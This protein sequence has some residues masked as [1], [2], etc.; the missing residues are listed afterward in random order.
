MIAQEKRVATIWDNEEGETVLRASCARIG[1]L[2]IKMKYKIALEQ[3]EEGWSVHVPGL[4]GCWSQGMNEEEAI[5]NI[6]DA[7]RDYLAARD[8][9]VEGANIREVDIPV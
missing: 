2:E 6:R 1:T 7:I 8:E 3:N 4:P 5:E 9:L